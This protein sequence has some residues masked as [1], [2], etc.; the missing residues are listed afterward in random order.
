M[1]GGSPWESGY[2]PTERKTSSGKLHVGGDLQ[3]FEVQRVKSPT[4]LEKTHA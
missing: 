2:F 1:S 4:R 3:R